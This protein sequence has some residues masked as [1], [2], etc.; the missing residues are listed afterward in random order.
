VHL[1]YPQLYPILNLPVSEGEVGNA[2]EPEEQG[3]VFLPL[4]YIGASTLR[5]LYPLLHLSFYTYYN[6]Y[7]TRTTYT[8]SVFVSLSSKEIFSCIDHV[9]HNKFRLFLS[10]NFYATSIPSQRK[11][12]CFNFNMIACRTHQLSDYNF[13]IIRVAVL[14]FQ[15]RQRPFIAVATRRLTSY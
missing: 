4:N 12:P 6:I 10:R 5:L 3:N 14:M 7:H 11:Q 13:S 9:R 15:T 8:D 2:W 1:H